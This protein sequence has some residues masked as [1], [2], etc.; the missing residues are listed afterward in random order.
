MYRPRRFPW[1]SG[2][3]GLPQVPLDPSAFKFS[4][5]GAVGLAQDVPNLVS[6]YDI[7]ETVG[8]TPFMSRPMLL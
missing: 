4:Y 6:I 1:R 7:V 2:Y 8:G 3:D 5:N